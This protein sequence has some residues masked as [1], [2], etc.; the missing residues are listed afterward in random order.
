MLAHPVGTQD[1]AAG[2]GALRL[3]LA[4][5]VLGWLSS[6]TARFLTRLVERDQT[7]L[8]QETPPMAQHRRPRP[9][10]TTASVVGGI[11]ALISGLVGSGLITGIQG[12]ALTGV[13][14]AIVAAAG[15]FGFAIAT[16]RKVTPTADPRDDQGLPLAPAEP[17][18][19]SDHKQS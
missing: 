4:A 10:R 12:D 9:V 8:E 11:T 14:N 6:I 17:P 18:I 5:V 13:I 2:D 19:A 1:T 16:E 7:R 15:A 3:F